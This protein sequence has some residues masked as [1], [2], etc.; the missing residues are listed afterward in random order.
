MH[1]LERMRSAVGLTSSL[2]SYFINTGLNKNPGLSAC[3]ESVAEKA[4]R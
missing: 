3:M 2:V 4:R 1:D